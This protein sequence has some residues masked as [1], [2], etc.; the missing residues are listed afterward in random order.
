MEVTDRHE[1][2]IARLNRSR[3]GIDGVASRAVLWDLHK[4][5]RR[6]S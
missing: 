1:L 3:T 2:V 6:G 4:N 5:I